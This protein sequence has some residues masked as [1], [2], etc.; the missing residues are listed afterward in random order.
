MSGITS[1]RKG[2]SFERTMAKWFRERVWPECE[3]TR[4]ADP[5][6][7]TLGIDLTNTD[8]FHIQCKY[9]QNI[10]IRKE[11]AKM[12]NTAN[13]KLLLHKK[14]NDG[15]IVAMSLSDFDKLLSKINP[16]DL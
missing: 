3:T 11:L 2:H 12:P 15:T 16:E 14:T 7:D 9:T 5:H 4:A 8:P 13:I 10:N 1:R 6:L